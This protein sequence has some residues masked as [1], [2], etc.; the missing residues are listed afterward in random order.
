MQI[1]SLK[2]K[3]DLR[4]THSLREIDNFCSCT[5]RVGGGIIVVLNYME[6]RVRPKKKINTGKIKHLNFTFSS[7]YFSNV[8][9]TDRSDANSV[10]E[11]HFFFMRLWMLP[12]NTYSISRQLLLTQAEVNKEQFY[13]L[14]FSYFNWNKTDLLQFMTFLIIYR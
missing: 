9:I 11:P 6:V 13:L 4:C 1:C 5:H 7:P 14:T 12:R 3:N 2:T 10:A 8:Q